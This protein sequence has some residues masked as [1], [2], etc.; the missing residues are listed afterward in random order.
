M[1]QTIDGTFEVVAVETSTMC[2][3]DVLPTDSTEG[4]LTPQTEDVDH[5][6]EV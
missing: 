1:P 2:L 5:S 6:L 3:S 4:S